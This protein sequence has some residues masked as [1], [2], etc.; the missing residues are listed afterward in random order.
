MHGAFLHTRAEQQFPVIE[1]AKRDRPAPCRP[2]SAIASISST[3]SSGHLRPCK[4]G[5]A[6]S[7]VRGPSR[8]MGESRHAVAFFPARMLREILC[9]RAGVTIA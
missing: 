9:R 5:T 8:L 4:E 2:A 1:I 7:A 3:M 6:E